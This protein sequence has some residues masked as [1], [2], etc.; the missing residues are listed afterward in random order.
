M[1][2]VE[3]KI[4]KEEEDILDY[5]NINNKKKESSNDNFKNKIKESN[6]KFCEYILE[7]NFYFRVNV[8]ESKIFYIEPDNNYIDNSQNKMLIIKNLLKNKFN[9]ENNKQ[10]QEY[11]YDDKIMMVFEEFTDKIKIICNLIIKKKKKMK[12]TMMKII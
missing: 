4:K 1:F 5:N 10:I 7:N 2:V 12:I 6:K 11:K 8:F 3:V 9:I